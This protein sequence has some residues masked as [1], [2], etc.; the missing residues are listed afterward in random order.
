VKKEV[1]VVLGYGAGTAT[2]IESLKSSETLASEVLAEGTETWFGCFMLFEVLAFS[3]KG[4]WEETSTI[5]FQEAFRLK[6]TPANKM[7]TANSTI[8][9]S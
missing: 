6:I 8:V 5:G 7:S 1:A 3:P 9:S 4:R 2:V